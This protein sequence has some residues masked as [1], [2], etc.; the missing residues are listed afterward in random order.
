MFVHC[1]EALQRIYERPIVV[2]GALHGALLI[3]I[4]P[5]NQLIS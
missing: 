1:L 3:D 2:K 5:K 4:H